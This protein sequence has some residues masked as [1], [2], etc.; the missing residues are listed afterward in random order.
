MA[1]RVSVVIMVFFSQVLVAI[2]AESFVVDIFDRKIRVSSPARH[3]PK[4]HVIL[5][6]KTLEAMVGKIQTARGR[7]IDYVSLSSGESRSVEIGQLKGEDMYYYPMAP[8]FQAVALV[9]GRPV[10]EIPEKR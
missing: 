1:G 8:A 5:H 2:S 3:S 7:V 9:I 4:L 10:Y 6:N